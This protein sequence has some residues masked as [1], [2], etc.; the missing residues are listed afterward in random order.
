MKFH[1]QLSW[2]WKFFYN[3]R[4]CSRFILLQYTVKPVLSGHS[5][6]KPKFQTDFHL[7]QVKNIAECSKGSILQ[8]F[9]PSL[10]YHLPLRSLC[11]LFLSGHLRQVLLYVIKVHKEL[12]EQTA[13][14]WIVKEKLRFTNL[15]KYLGFISDSSKDILK[16]GVYLR[17]NFLISLPK[18]MFISMQEFFW[19][20][21][22]SLSR[23]MRFPKMWY[24]QPAKV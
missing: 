4:A 9:R 3:L 1:A 7:M 6:R 5:K 15:P 10:S 11:Y 17:I 13:I 22:T 2:A 24:V 23:D 16:L 14:G 20:L 21:K 12:G 19:V 8:Y 18:H